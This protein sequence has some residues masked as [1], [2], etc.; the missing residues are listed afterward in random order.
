VYTVQSFAQP[1][2]VQNPQPAAAGAQNVSGLGRGQLR[3]L[4]CD[5][6]GHI[7]KGCPRPKY[8][9]FDCCNFWQRHRDECPELA[10]AQAVHLQNMLE[11]NPSNFLETDDIVS[12][13]SADQEP[14]EM[15]ALNDEEE[16]ESTSESSAYESLESDI[17]DS[18][19]EKYAG[20]SLEGR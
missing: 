11:A 18:D 9:Y 1:T 10:K 16:I 19:H 17:D 20:K 2:N 3:C 6:F 5:S 12:L 4:A 14:T 7:A 13:C 15:F 8:P